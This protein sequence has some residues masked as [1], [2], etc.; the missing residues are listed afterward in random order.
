[1]SLE[2]ANVIDAL[3][4]DEGSGR[5]TFIIRHDGAWDGSKMQLYMLQEKLNAYLSFA[6][7]GEMA[8]A[9]PEFANH[10][11]AV[12]IDTTAAPDERTLRFLAQVRR[13]LG[14]Q[15]IPL[16]VRLAPAPAPDGQEHQCR[17]GSP[18]HPQP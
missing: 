15:D 6:L 13:Q 1:M 8:E 3:G 17:C 12:R 16:E 5:V 14:F 11:L 18:D 10:P 4:L 7:D 2:A 9:Y